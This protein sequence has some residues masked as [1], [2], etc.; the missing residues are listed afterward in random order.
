MLEK[1]LRYIYNSYH[2][3]PQVHTTSSC[4]LDCWVFFKNQTR[5][6][7]MQ[8]M[9]LGPE[10]AWSHIGEIDH[11]R[12]IHTGVAGIITASLSDRIGRRP[13]L[14]TCTTLLMIGSFLCGCATR[15]WAQ[16]WAVWLAEEQTEV[17]R[18]TCCIIASS[19]VKVR[20]RTANNGNNVCFQICL[21]SSDCLECVIL[22][23]YI[24]YQ[25]VFHAFLWRSHNQGIENFIAARVLQGLGEAVEPVIIAM[26][27]A[28]D[29]QL[30]VE[31]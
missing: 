30:V 18:Q 6:Q 2:R 5:S 1:I 26:A 9:M 12:L 15:Y 19:K 21:F 10:M 3:H 4:V 13:V 23:I 16:K 25:P 14:L 22:Y 31:L 29:L 7:R 28:L 20:K 11:H 27:R 17:V 8:L 24:Y